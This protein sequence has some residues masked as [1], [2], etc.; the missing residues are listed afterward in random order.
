MNKEEMTELERELENLIV[1]IDGDYAVFMSN[2]D[3][4]IKKYAPSIL[5]AARRQIID[6]ERSAAEKM[7][8]LANAQTGVDPDIQQVVN[9]HFFEM[10]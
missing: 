1:E 6:E 9:D 5:A 10:L 8:N 2:Y 4:Y 7:L 3:D